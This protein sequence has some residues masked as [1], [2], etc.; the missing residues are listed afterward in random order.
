M[1]LLRNSPNKVVAIEDKIFSNRVEAKVDQFESL[2]LEGYGL[3]VLM[4]SL[5]LREAELYPAVAKRFNYSDD[6]I[7]KMLPTCKCRRRA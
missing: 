7:K 3:P 1:F 6:L 4:S 5:K 2:L